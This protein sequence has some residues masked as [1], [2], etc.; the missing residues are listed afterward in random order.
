MAFPSC[1]SS[2]GLLAQ[3]WL[4]REY[5]G[6]DEFNSILK[7]YLRWPFPFPLIFIKVVLA[8]Q[9]LFVAT[10]NTKSKTIQYAFFSS[11]SFSRSVKIWNVTMSNENTHLINLFENNFHLIDFGCGKWSKHGFNSVPDKWNRINV[12]NRLSYF[13][14]CQ[15]NDF[16][17]GRNAPEFT[18]TWH[19]AKTIQTNQ[20]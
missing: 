5:F 11:F 3:K 9:W 19:I 17:L 2:V 8:F 20:N 1:E 14:I 15:Q 12:Q 18:P 4:T 16:I 7:W 10:G 6:F 13:Y